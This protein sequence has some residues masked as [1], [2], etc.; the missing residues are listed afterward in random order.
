M[1]AQHSSPAH[2]EA[3][4]LV[5][6]ADP[7]LHPEAVH[8]AAATTR[9]VVD[10]AEVGDGDQ[11]FRYASRAAA[12]LVDSEHAHH[13][14]GIDSAVPVFFLTS[15]RTPMD[16]EKALAVRA[17]KAFILPA[18]SAEILTELAEIA[19][20]SSTASTSHRHGRGISLAVTASAGGAGTS[21]FAAALARTVA[22]TREPVTLI[23]ADPT[24]GGLDLLLGIEDAPGTRWPDLLL[25][26]S[27]GIDPN[28]L[29]A[30]LPATT[31]GVAVLS[32]ARTTIDDPF[33]LEN[34]MVVR[35]VDTL[36]PASGWTIVDLPPGD[37]PPPVDMV[38][39]LVPAEVR[40]AAAATRILAGLRSQRLETFVVARR[41]G[42]AGLDDSD[43]A[44]V[45]G[46]DPLASLDNLA[47]VAKDSE[48]TG[49]PGRLPAPLRAVATAVL[50]HAGG[51]Q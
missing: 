8:V 9:P 14:V 15:D 18:Q 27:G 39:L 42:W 29:R 47:T 19:E 3:F 41:R 37:A 40:P 1:P 20:P 33:R 5:A 16:W 51:V 50:E 38:V 44:K 46:C 21:T 34:E 31:D 6:V 25:T 48:I 32:A 24:S 7:V 22:K 4:L 17:C 12:V 10:L 11:L 23:D 35:I 28:D 2:S 36:A 26:D 13:L 49:L 30:A 45:L 43:L